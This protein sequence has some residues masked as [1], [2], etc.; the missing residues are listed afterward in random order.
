MLNTKA[1]SGL[2]KISK[3]VRKFRLFSKEGLSVIGKKL[4]KRFIKEVSQPH[5]ENSAAV[6]GVFYAYPIQ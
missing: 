3:K 6:Q 1:F 5:G 2:V 4:S